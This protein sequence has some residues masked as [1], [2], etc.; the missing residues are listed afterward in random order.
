MAVRKTYK[1]KFIRVKF[2]IEK[3]GIV[4]TEEVK[5]RLGKGIVTDKAIKNV[6]GEHYELPHSIVSIETITETYEMEDNEFIEKATKIE[7]D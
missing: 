7:E 2:Y 6:M 3:E 1:H 4:T 5:F